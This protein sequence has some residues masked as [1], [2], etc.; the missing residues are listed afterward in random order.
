MIFYFFCVR[1]FLRILK[2][3]HNEHS[4]VLNNTIYNFLKE[5]TLRQK[6]VH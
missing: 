5:D 6:R 4:L 2:T 1:V 3:I